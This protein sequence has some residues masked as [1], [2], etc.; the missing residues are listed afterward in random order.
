MNTTKL[1]STISFNTPS[2]LAGKLRSLVTEGVI[3]FAHWIYHQPED[4][5]K[6]GHFHL[7][8][9][10][11]RRL[12]TGALQNEFKEPVAGEDKPLGVLPFKNSKMQDWI[13]YAV[14]DKAY[15]IRKNRQQRKFS[16]DQSEIKTTDSD[17]LEEDW[18]EAHENEDSRVKQVIEMA[19]NGVTWPEIIRLGVIPV[20]QLF[21]YKDIFFT[22][23]DVKT[24]RRGREGHDDEA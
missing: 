1:I 6:K 11:N 23:V 3:E 22:C 18:R 4:D 15:L 14:H 10:P 16:Y 2:F 24:N 21:Q 7:V 5:E 17:L 8:L 20:N 9:K 19:E 13:L 12:N